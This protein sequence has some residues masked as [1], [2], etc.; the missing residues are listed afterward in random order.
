[1]T[2]LWTFR[3]YVDQNGSSDVRRAWERASAQVR[4]KFKS[5]LI[6]LAHLPLSEWHETYFKRLSGPDSGLAEIRFKADRVQQ[7]PLGFHSGPN[8]FTLLFW[9][10]EKGGEFRPRSACNIALRRK[11]EVISGGRQTDVLWIALE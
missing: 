8:E 10:T 11:A 1:M 3:H 4:A 5:R 9:A 2:A 7:R 6:D